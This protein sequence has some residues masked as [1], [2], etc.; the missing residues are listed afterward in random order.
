MFAV[1]K[2]YYE[3]SLAV[4]TSIFFGA[5]AYFITYIITDII[6]YLWEK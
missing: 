6:Q 2:F 4:D 3:W 1:I 5:V